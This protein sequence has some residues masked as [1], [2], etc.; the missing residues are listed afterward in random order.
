MVGTRGTLLRLMCMVG[1]SFIIAHYGVCQN[2]ERSP[3]VILREQA[4][5]IALEI[6]EQWKEPLAVKDK[7]ILQIAENPVKMLLENGF[8]EAFTKQGKKISTGNV[9][10]SS[11]TVLKIFPLE[12]SIRSMEL[13]EGSIQRT[14]QLSLEGRIETAEGIFL[15]PS[16]IYR[17]QVVDTV[18]SPQR[19]GA[20]SFLSPE[21]VGEESWFDK[22]ASPLFLISAAFVI[23]Y[24]FFHVRS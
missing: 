1:L 23:I 9:S 19:G 3:Q 21:D 17:R 18:L 6:L 13:H 14:I 12:A 20:I 5:G 16:S 4:L 8:I 22:I 10:E 24:L 15:V 11:A 2:A 7:V